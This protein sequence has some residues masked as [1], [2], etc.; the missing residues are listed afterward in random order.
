MGL[1]YA[2]MFIHYFFLNKCQK[3]LRA[4]RELVYHQLSKDCSLRTTVKGQVK[5]H[6][7]R[8]RSVVEQLEVKITWLH[9]VL[10]PWLRWHGTQ[11]LF[12]KKQQW[13]S[14]L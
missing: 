7:T 12:Y 13:Q 11:R 4:P 1:D 8:V 3:L 2:N 6:F 10:N 9:F 5:M 14:L